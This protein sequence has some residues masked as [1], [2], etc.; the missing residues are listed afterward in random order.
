MSRRMIATSL[1]FIS[2]VCYSITLNPSVGSGDSG[3]LITV[4]NTLGIAHPPG[5]P[6][7]SILGRLFSLIPVG[8]IAQRVNLISLLSAVAVI[9][10]IFLLLN[11]EMVPAITASLVFAFSYTFWS[12]SSAA[13]VYTLNLLLLLLSLWSINRWCRE[14]DSRFLLLFGSILGLGISHRL[15]FLLYFPAFGYAIFYTG[16]RSN[17]KIGFGPMALFILALSILFYLPIRAGANPDINWGNPDNVSRFLSHIAALQYRG[18]LFTLPLVSVLQRITLFPRILLREFTLIIVVAIPGIYYGLK[19]RKELFMPL[20]IIL[21][22]N[23]LYTI[24][25]DIP[26]YDVYFLPTFLVLAIW[27][28]MGIEYISSI[29]RSRF[30]YVIILLPIAPFLANFSKNLENRQ[31]YAYDCAYNTIKSLPSNAIFVTSSTVFANGIIY[32]QQIEKQKIGID[33]VLYDMLKSPAYFQMIKN[34]IGIQARSEEAIILNIINS[35]YGRRPICFGIDMMKEVFFAL[36]GGN[37]NYFVIP[38]GL[39]NRI[40]KRGPLNRQKIVAK[41]DSLWNSFKFRGIAE[42]GYPK[43]KYGQIQL[44]YGAAINNIGSFY[45]DQEW[46][47]EAERILHSALGFPNRPGV[48]R[49]IRQNLMIIS[50]RRPNHQ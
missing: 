36:R 20:L 44:I 32:L 41:N 28:G 24:N 22:L 27:L 43:T 2:L 26:D 12:E 17:L 29:I 45:I 30:K 25:Y 23:F 48:E 1:I 21:I 5:Y 46:F 16:K 6:L 31:Y 39:V 33:I 38:E 40:K 9:G 50:K 10:L 14:R 15:T 49:T 35:N 47:Y 42:G 18:F 4:A 8:S 34:K 19:K 37:G 11:R 3:E 13:E 7:F